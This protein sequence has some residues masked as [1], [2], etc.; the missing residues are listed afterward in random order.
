MSMVFQT[1]HNLNRIHLLPNHIK[2]HSEQLLIK[3][4][5]YKIYPVLFVAQ[6]QVL[7][8][9]T[10]LMPLQLNITEQEKQTLFTKTPLMQFNPIV[11]NAHV[12]KVV[13]HQHLPKQ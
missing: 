12:S 1:V 3:E 2:D 11:A 8:F 6:Q 9:L 5:M 13:R 10:I 4:Q 7:K